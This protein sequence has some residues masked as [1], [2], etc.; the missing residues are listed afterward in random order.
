MCLT[1]VR[2]EWLS[3]RLCI[4]YI[5]SQTKEQ[6]LADSRCSVNTCQTNDSNARIGQYL[7]SEKIS[8]FPPEKPEEDFAL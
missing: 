1:R 2:P 8:Q 6:G 3:Q 5:F 7:K 4:A